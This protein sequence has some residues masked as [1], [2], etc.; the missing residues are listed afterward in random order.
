MQALWENGTDYTLLS[1]IQENYSK[2]AHLGSL[3]FRKDFNPI[4]LDDV[5]TCSFWATG[6]RILRDPIHP[7]GV[8]C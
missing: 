8:T 6:T 3:M 2:E 4:Q 7:L 1:Y 5:L